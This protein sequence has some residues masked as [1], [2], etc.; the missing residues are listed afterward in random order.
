MIKENASCVEQMNIMMTLCVFLDIL[1]L[2]GVNS[3]I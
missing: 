3:Y 2:I 1:V